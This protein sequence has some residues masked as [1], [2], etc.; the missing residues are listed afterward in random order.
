MNVRMLLQFAAISCSVGAQSE[1]TS[2]VD[3]AFSQELLSRAQE[4]RRI[5]RNLQ[6][7][8]FE[9]LEAFK[10]SIETVRAAAEK[11]SAVV[12][13]I[14]ASVFEDLELAVAMLGRVNDTCNWRGIPPTGNLTPFEANKQAIDRIADTI[15]LIKSKRRQK[16]SAESSSASI[17]T[18]LMDVDELLVQIDAQYQAA[19]DHA[20]S[21]EWGRA[22]NDERVTDVL[23]KAISAS[24][25]LSACY[26]ALGTDISDADIQKYN[27]LAN[28][29]QSTRG[30][31]AIKLIR[32]AIEKQTADHATW[33]NRD[34]VDIERFVRSVN[35][36]DPPAESKDVKDL[37]SRNAQLAKELLLAKDEQNRE[38]IRHRRLIELNELDVSGKIRVIEAA[39]AKLSTD[40][41]ELRGKL[42]DVF[43]EKLVGGLVSGTIGLIFGWLGARMRKEDGTKKRGK[44]Q[45]SAIS[46]T[47]TSPSG[48]SNQQ[49]G[50]DSHQDSGAKRKSVPNA[51]KKDEK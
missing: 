14:S 44:L 25:S 5:E 35:Q 37:Q 19:V 26:F 49:S 30:L 13:D 31:G 38:D 24:R 50:A 29:F 8:T 21:A 4:L 32:T 15:R 41:N 11:E 40:N 1:S 43:W 51:K 10:R 7:H 6:S 9:Q 39:K 20:K 36:Y 3:L 2:K 48:G 28:Q 18:A 42:N 23:F 47:T 16:Y 45:A 34:I 17:T 27:K 12:G 22:T 46:P 33:A